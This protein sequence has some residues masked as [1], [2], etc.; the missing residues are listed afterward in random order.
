MTI[1]SPLASA[2]SGPG[3]AEINA[4]CLL[5]GDQVTSAP[6]PGNGAFVP[7]VSVKNVVEV[8]SGCTTPSPCFPS[9]APSYAIH[10]ESGDQTAPPDTSCSPPI[11]VV[12]PLATSST[13]NCGRGLPG[14]SYRTTVYATNFPSGEIDA[15]PTDRIR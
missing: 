12:F 15:P 3:V 11:R 14:R 6:V 7:L 4:I 2:V 13:H 9:A 8:P 5:S 10:R 1:G